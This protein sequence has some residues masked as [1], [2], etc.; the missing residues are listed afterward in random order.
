MS[1]IFAAL[2]GVL[3]IDN[4][5]IAEKLKRHAGMN[6]LHLYFTALNEAVVFECIPTS[7]KC[8]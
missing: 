6:L 2:E 3:V 8:V 5:L 7:I 4:L 1:I